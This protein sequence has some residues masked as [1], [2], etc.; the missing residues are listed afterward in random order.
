MKFSTKA[1]S[2]AEEPNLSGETSSDVIS[3]IHLASTF[4]KPDF[5]NTIRGFGYSRLTI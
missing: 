3:S 5:E 4:A 2:V 1:I